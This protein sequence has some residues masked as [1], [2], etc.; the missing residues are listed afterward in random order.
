M[1]VAL[2]K[3][4][5]PQR[6]E[7][8]QASKSQVTLSSPQL[9]YLYQRFMAAAKPLIRPHVSNPLF[10]LFPP[11]SGI[12]VALLNPAICGKNSYCEEQDAY[13]RLAHVS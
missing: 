6:L 13:V 12:V 5:L 8:S 2:E 3:E 4:D 9:P 10:L 11:D 1:K 7:A